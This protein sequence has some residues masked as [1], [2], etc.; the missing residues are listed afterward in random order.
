MAGATQPGKM[1]V[2]SLCST[3]RRSVAVGRRR[4]V[5][6]LVDGRGVP[7]L[8]VVGVGGDAEAPQLPLQLCGSPPPDPVQHRVDHGAGHLDIHVA[9]LQHQHPGP[10]HIDPARQQ[11]R[12][13]RRE[14]L[15][16]QLSEAELP[17]GL[18]FVHRNAAWISA[19]AASSHTA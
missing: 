8:G 1:H 3:P 19:A 9:R 15:P 7:L 14:A 10:G 5:P 6:V 17:L 16:E 4:V 18:R 2:S 11:R 13:N 12:M